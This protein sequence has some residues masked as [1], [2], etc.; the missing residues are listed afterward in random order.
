MKSSDPL[1]PPISPR[2]ALMI[3]GNYWTSPIQVGSHHLA[4]ALVAAGW[5]VAFISDPIS[6]LHAIAGVDFPQRLALYRQGG[7]WDLDGRLWAYVPGALLTPQNRPLLRSHWLSQHWQ[8]LSAPSAAR[9]ASNHGFAAV[10]LVYFDSFSQPF[11]LEAIPH[12]RSVFRIVDQLSAYPKA[13]PAAELNIA[14]LAQQVDLVAYT[15]YSLEPYV[16]GLR[17]RRMFH[18]PNG[19]AYQHF[20][21][22]LPPIPTELSAIPQPIAMYIG[23]LESW[24]DYDLVQQAAEQLPGVSFVLIGPEKQAVARLKPRPNLHILGRR[25]HDQAPAY[26]RHAQ[27]GLI[28]FNYQ[29][30]PLLVNHINPIK[31]YE[32]LAC[33]LP[34]VSMEWEELRRLGSPA[35]LCRSRQDFINAIP[36]ILEKPPAP[37]AAKRFAESAGWGQRASALLAELGLD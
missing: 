32:Y 19:V 23:S 5:Q 6:P 26:L 37:E 35:I 33:G 8:R 27:I 9:A 1:S 28:P 12:R 31:L 30:Q 7:S 21:G 17:P 25:P 29:E 15:A 10:D 11:W 22:P 16:S 24:F 18:L 3:C 4:R 13:T 2:K 14:A 20:A 34:V 36:A